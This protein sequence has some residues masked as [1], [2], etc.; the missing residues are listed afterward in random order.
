M[1]RLRYLLLPLAALAGAGLAVLLRDTPSPPAPHVTCR[2]SAPALAAVR[3]EEP[4]VLF[5]GNSLLFDGTWAGLGF[6]P[7]NCAH[8]GMTAGVAVGRTDLL[9]E[10]EVAAI[11]LAFGSVELL[12]ERAIDTDLFAATMI[13]IRDRLRE[14]YGPVP[15]LVSGVPMTEL[16]EPAWGYLSP[17]VSARVNRVL[18]DLSGTTY[19]DLSRVLSDIGPK[20]QTY[21][22]I[23]LTGAAYA[24]W[25]QAIAQALR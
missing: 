17:D 6:L 3:S 14:K 10:M 21:D 18:R 4:A 22:G 8:Q 12:R 19:L 16:A 13:G 24:A 25:G 9:P 2:P 11:V 20:Q 1:A 15:I 7:V 5:W 23:H